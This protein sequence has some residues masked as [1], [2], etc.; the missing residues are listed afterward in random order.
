MMEEYLK[1][2]D[3]A[4]NYENMI[5]RFYLY[6]RIEFWMEDIDSEVEL[7]KKTYQSIDYV[8]YYYDVVDEI[9]DIIRIL[10]T[11]Y[12]SRY[13]FR[14]YAEYC[15]KNY[16]LVRDTD[17]DIVNEF[18]QWIK[19]HRKKNKRLL[20]RNAEE[21]FNLSPL[22][23]KRFS[24]TSEIVAKIES[25]LLK[26]NIYCEFVT[27]HNGSGDIVADDYMIGY[28]DLGNDDYVDFQ[29]YYIIDNLNQFYITETKIIEVSL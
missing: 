26:R 21:I 24:T 23:H 10:I 27:L 2:K 1:F 9:A 3:G 13:E 8:K 6:T 14:D 19:I 28:I 12:G 29:I 25:L 4:D 7:D 18:Y 17:F 15:V 5:T 16:T 20:M 22:L 11:A